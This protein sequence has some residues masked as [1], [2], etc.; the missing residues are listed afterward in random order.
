MQAERREAGSEAEGSQ[1][2]PRDE[3]G[4]LVV[5]GADA[6]DEGGRLLGAHL[7]V[8]IGSGEQ[9]A[10]DHLWHV[11]A[12]GGMHLRAVPGL[13]AKPRACE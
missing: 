11:D 1:C 6:R 8:K 4:R 10:E 5:E 3:G 13:F 7:V 9:R 2:K 12:L